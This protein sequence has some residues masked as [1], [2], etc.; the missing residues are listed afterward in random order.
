MKK[1]SLKKYLSLLLAMMI[2][3]MTAG[4]GEQKTAEEQKPEPPVSQEQEK[5]E[6]EEKSDHYP[7]TIQTY[8]HSKEPIELVF[9]KAPERVYAVNPTS[10]EN[11]IALGLEDKIVKVSLG[12]RDRLTEAGK[13]LY[14]K[15]GGQ[16]PT[17]TKEEVLGNNIDFILG[18]YSTFDEK[19]L[20]E[21]DYWHEKGIKTYIALN[22]SIKKPAP[23]TLED[24][25]EDIRNL[26][27]IF[28]VEEKAEQIIKEMDASI[29]AAQEKVKEKGKT[30]VIVLEV[31]KDN[32]IRLYGPETIGG[33]IAEKVGADL[34]TNEP[35]ITAEQLI[36]LNP[37]VI[38]SVYFGPDTDL[39]EESCITKLT[40]N[41]ALKSISAIQSGKV[42]PITLSY[43][44]ATGVRTLEA[45][46]YI[47]EILHPELAQ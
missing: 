29:A 12:S 18:W 23:N 39:T 26:G 8:R 38:F 5:K 22:S 1:I 13:A 31:E 44:Y 47:S 11:M 42:Y 45:I 24:E 35:R 19:T 21:V 6:P 32:Q 10:V 41:P 36:E 34:L 9:E 17:L 33:V 28:N 37:D 4:C 7:V 46:H 25:Y 3:L 15:L 40:E 30:R 43:T 16:K 14:D 2:L 20:G 27:R